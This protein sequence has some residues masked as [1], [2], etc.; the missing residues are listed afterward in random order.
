MAV[1]MVVFP[2][3]GV[4]V[5]QD[6]TVEARV[7][8]AATASAA[9][10][11]LLA[12]LIAVPPSLDFQLSHAHLRAAGDL[13]PLA[14]A[15]GA[16]LARRLQRHRLVALHAPRAA[17]LEIDLQARAFGEGRTRRRIEAETQG[18]RLDR[19]ERTDL[20]AD[21]SDA[22]KA[23]LARSILRD[24]KHA[25]DQRHLVHVKLASAETRTDHFLREGGRLF[26]LYQQPARPAQ[27][28][29]NDRP[30]VTLQHLER[31]FSKALLPALV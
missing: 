14:P 9:H 19:G 29:E 1:R 6:F 26:D 22:G 27:S 16:A 2:D 12:R 4:L 17:R 13:K 28:M 31:A 18:L 20:E 21:G 23:F 7:P 25:L 15:L 11:P 8:F 3:R 10:H 5:G 24:A 30:N